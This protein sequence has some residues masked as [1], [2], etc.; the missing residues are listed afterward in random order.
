MVICL[1]WATLG[2]WPNSQLILKIKFCAIVLKLLVYLSGGIGVH[3]GTINIEHNGKW[4]TVCDDDFGNSDAKVICRS[5][6]FYGSLVWQF[7]QIS[8]L[9]LKW[10]K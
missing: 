9:G 7:V 8:N 6:G 10:K 2:Q 1:R 4:G 5:L 3:E